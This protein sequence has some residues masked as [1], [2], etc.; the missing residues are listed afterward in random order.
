[1]RVSFDGAP[2]ARSLSREEA[3]NLVVGCAFGSG[4]E[5][6]CPFKFICQQWSDPTNRRM[7]ESLTLYGFGYCR[8][9]S[10]LFFISIH[11]KQV[12]FYINFE[13]TKEQHNIRT[14]TRRRDRNVKAR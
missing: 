14:R 3:N 8:S 7:T 6:H 12:V 11:E 2:A 1:M 5:R 9:A 13:C 4:R 10:R